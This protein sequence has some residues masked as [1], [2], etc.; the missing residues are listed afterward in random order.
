MSI[1]IS[2]LTAILLTH[3]TKSQSVETLLHST[4]SSAQ[5][6]AR[7][8]SLFTTS[9]QEDC[10]TIC[11]IVQANPT[12]SICRFPTLCTGGCKTACQ[13]LDKV[14][15]VRSTIRMTSL[16]QQS[17]QLVWQ[18]EMKETEN[19]TF[20]VA[21]R[22][23]SGMWN[24]LFKKISEKSVELTEQMTG[25]FVEVTVLAVNKEG[26]VDK[27]T[28]EI[29]HAKC[30]DNDEHS[31]KNDAGK[32]SVEIEASSPVCTDSLKCVHLVKLC[33]SSV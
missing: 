12:T 4:I 1:Q 21:G 14:D 11:P 7:C 18:V 32:N 33:T 6:Q 13:K 25:K 2:I 16:V 27:A 31:E 5:C 8:L 23:Q 24:L 29:E 28:V 3:P 20:V 17:C 9:D 15:S 19:V 22:D 26:V 30:G 10:L